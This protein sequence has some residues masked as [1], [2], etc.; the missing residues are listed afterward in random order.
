[1][2]KDIYLLSSE[3]KQLL[4]ADER[5]IFLNQLEKE[6]NANQEV[7]LLAYQKDMAISEYSDL[8]NHFSLEEEIVK[9][10][11]HQLYEKKKALDEHPLVRRYLL[12]Y[13]QVRDL[14]LEISDI[15]FNGLNMHMKENR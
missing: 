6:M 15:L 1:M 13:S 12:V 5:L 7:M 2:N 14:Y 8:L 3:L 9:K 4:N 10:A 11:Q